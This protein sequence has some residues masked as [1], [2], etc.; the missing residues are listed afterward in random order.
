[1]APIL[2]RPIAVVSKYPKDPKFGDASGQIGT[3]EYPGDVG[4]LS[5]SPFPLTHKER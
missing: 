2:E 4:F 1:M 3:F 5:T